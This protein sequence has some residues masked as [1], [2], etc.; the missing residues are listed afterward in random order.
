MLVMARIAS[1]ADRGSRLRVVSRRRLRCRSLR[2][3]V[4][5]LGLALA[6]LDGERRL[7]L[8]LDQPPRRPNDAG[9]ERQKY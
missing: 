4:G 7:P 3:G 2:L 5:A 9:N 8:G 1:S 6:S